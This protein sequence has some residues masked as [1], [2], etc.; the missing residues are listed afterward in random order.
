M[1]YIKK[2]FKQISFVDIIIDERVDK[3]ESKLFSFLSWLIHPQISE[4]S[5]YTFFARNL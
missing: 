2:C 1:Y 3:K 5:L 4:S